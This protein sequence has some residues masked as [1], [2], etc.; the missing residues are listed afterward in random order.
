[1]MRKLLLIAGVAAL[2]LPGL[3]SAQPGCVEQQH[4][5]RV[6][7]TVFGAGLGAIFGGAVT[8]RGSGAALGALG[9]AA[10]GNVAGG[11]SVRCDHFSQ[12]GYYDT[13]GVWHYGDGYYDND[14]RWHQASGADDSDGKWVEGVR[15]TPPSAGEYGA[16]VAYVGAPGDIP[17]RE[18]WLE[19]RI[20]RG[21]DAG[22]ISH[23]DADTDRGRLSSIRDME[24]RLRGDH[25]GLNDQ[26]RADLTA[27]LDDLGAAVDSQWRPAD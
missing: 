19:G 18:S 22:A 26:D 17:G 14:G 16:D 23:Y 6:A 20:R 13:N 1:M 12:E 24:G 8:G 3:A 10:V 9:G 21:E 2:A 5:N 7:G 15:P 4:D 27:R 11:S 25:D